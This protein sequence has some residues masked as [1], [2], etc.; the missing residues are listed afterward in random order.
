[1][2]PTSMFAALG[3]AE[4]VQTRHY[5][6]VYSHVVQ[7]IRTQPFFL[8]RGSFRFQKALLGVSSFRGPE[9]EN[10][11]FPP[12]PRHSL[13][14]SKKAFGHFL[15]YYFTQPDESGGPQRREEGEGGEERAFRHQMKSR[16]EREKG[17]QALGPF[18]SNASVCPLL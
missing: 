12:P 17:S 2:K 5:S 4:Y 1:M 14:T 10:S 6:L 18:V 13:Y 3:G 16:K 15:P 8:P 7:C 11:V 9:K